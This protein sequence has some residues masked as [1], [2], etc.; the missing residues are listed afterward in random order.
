MRRPRVT[1]GMLM[2]WVAYAAW[3]LRHSLPLIGIRRKSRRGRRSAVVLASLCL[4][5]LLAVIRRGR[6][7]GGV[8]AGMAVF[9]LGYLAFAWL[10]EGRPF[11]THN[12]IDRPCLG[13]ARR[14]SIIYRSI[15][16]MGHPP[17]PR[18]IT[19]RPTARRIGHCASVL[20]IGIVGS[21]LGTSGPAGSRRVRVEGRAS[22]V[23]DRPGIAAGPASAEYP[24]TSIILRRGNRILLRPPDL[25]L[26]QRHRSRVRP[27]PARHLARPLR[28]LAWAHYR[29]PPAAVR[30]R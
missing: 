29:N 22:P 13:L 3:L 20:A 8:R 4:A 16:G 18:G 27:C 21:V 30:H 7:R 26:R 9:G 28:A 14:G 5:A 12:V 11:A 23:G 24:I 6:A 15:Q 2:V 10:A 1:I 25:R 19:E 17:L